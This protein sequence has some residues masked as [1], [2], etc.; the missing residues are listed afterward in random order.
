M[1][2]PIG[3]ASITAGNGG[4][5]V[6]PRERGGTTID[7]VSERVRS[8]THAIRE[9]TA[10]IEQIAEAVMGSPPSPTTTNPKMDHPPQ[11]LQEHISCLEDAVTIL[12][13][14]ISR[15]F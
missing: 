13:Q 1:Q 11:T 2:T 6:A 12:D 15:F 14:Q 8:V 10:R 5:G 3:R 4:P 9:I 7:S